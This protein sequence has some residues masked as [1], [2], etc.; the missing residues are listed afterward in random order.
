[1]YWAGRAHDQIGDTLVANDRYRLEVA[2][3]G[4]SYYGRL[5]SKILASRNVPAGANNVTIG[6]TLAAPQIPTGA[7]IRQ[8][9]DLNLYDLALKALQYAQRAW[10]DAPAVQATIA[11]IRHEQAHTEVAPDRFDHLRGAIN[12]MKRAYPQYLAAGGQNLPP[13]VLEVIYP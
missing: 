5:A 8:L 2:D 3:Y 13:A 9:V 7:L 4:N 6:A 1:L 10:G 12:I 11:W